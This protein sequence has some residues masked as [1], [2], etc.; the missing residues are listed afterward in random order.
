M[1][2]WL[3]VS[4]KLH[5]STLLLCF[6]KHDQ[7]SIWTWNGVTKIN[8]C[9]RKAKLPFN[10]SVDLSKYHPQ[11]WIYISALGCFIGPVLKIIIFVLLYLTSYLTEIWNVLIQQVSPSYLL[12]SD[13]N[14]QHLSLEPV[15]NWCWSPFFLYFSLSPSYSVFIYFRLLDLLP[16]LSSYLSTYLFIVFIYV[17]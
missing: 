1:T 17:Q 10:S 7:H 15:P 8:E 16:S 14:G 4:Q 2:E 6:Y 11:I 12:S 5:F 13:K 9:S 3:I